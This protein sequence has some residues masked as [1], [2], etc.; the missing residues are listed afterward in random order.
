MRNQIT[1]L[2]TISI[3]IP[4]SPEVAFNHLLYDVAKFW[5]EDFEGKSAKLNDEFTFTTSGDSHYSKIRWLNW[6]PTKR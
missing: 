1:A 5:P 6:C 2:Y 3:E 4:K